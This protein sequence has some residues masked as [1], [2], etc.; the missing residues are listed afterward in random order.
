ML[1][2]RHQPSL[3]PVPASRTRAGRRAKQ[4]GIAIVEAALALPVFVLIALATIDTCR[5][6]YVRQ[7]AKLAAY[8]AA[9]V[10]II[11]GA[12]REDISAQ[13]KSMLD[14]RRIQDYRLTLSTS[15]PKL[16][17]KGELLKVTVSVP[18]NANA[19]AT[20]WFYR[21]REFDESVTIMAEY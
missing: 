11:P 10:G 3:P 18:A 15:D 2:C 16:L 4:M 19:F 8:E 1:K 9:R 17:V 12:T 7:S 20:S 14:R 13:C 6:I 5:V 21:D